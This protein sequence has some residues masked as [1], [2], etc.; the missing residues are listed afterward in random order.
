MRGYLT[1]EEEFRLAEIFVDG[2]AKVTPPQYVRDFTELHLQGLVWVK[3]DK[4]V[5]LS[6]KGRDKARAICK[7]HG[8]G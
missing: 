7:E 5:R 6:K 2:A 8:L 3:E 4:L 1:Q